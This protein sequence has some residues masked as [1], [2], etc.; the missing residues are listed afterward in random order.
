[1]KHEQLWVVELWGNRTKW[2]EGWTTTVGVDLTRDD[3][4]RELAAWRARNPSD[5]FR[6]RRYSPAKASR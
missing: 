5:R 1:M 3:A 2:T 4:R 6:L